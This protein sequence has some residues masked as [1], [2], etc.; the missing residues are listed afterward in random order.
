MSRNIFLDLGTHYGE[1]LREFIQKHHMNESWIIHTFEANPTVYQMFVTEYLSQTPWVIPHLTAVSDH[2]GTIQVNIESPP[3]EGATGMGT[4]IIDLERWNPWDGNI[5]EN[6]KHQEVVPC[7]D[8]AEF[9]SSHVT[10]DDYLIIKM[11][12]EGAEYDVLEKMMVSDVL[13]Y[14]DHIAIEWHSRFFTNQEVM[15]EREARIVDYLHQHHVEF[16]SWR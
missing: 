13:R 16:E 15:Y 5:R 6:F 1:G 2:N 12:I 9:I 14:V 11:D 4:S 7:L 3:N 10:M 8:L